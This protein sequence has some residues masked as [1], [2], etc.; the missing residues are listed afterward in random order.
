M[1]F[2]GKKL[3]QLGYDKETIELILDAWRTSTKKVYTTYLKK[4]AVFCVRQGVKILSPKLT[5]AC[6]FLKNISKEGSG[7]GAVN[8]ARSA[9]SAILPQ[10]EGHSFGTHPMVC[11]L[12]KGAYNRNPPKARYTCFWDVRKVFRVFKDWGPSKDLTLKL[13]TLKLTVLLLL[14]TSQRGQTILGLSIDDLEVSNVAVFKLKVLLKHNRLGD[15]LDTIVLK[16]YTESKRLCVVTTLKE[17]LR[18]TK[19]LRK[20]ETQLLISFLKPN[21]AISRDTL[22]RWTIKVLQMADID[23]QKYKGHSTRGASASAAK[24]LGCSLNQ[25]M[26]QAG[27]KSVESF[28]R[29]YDKDLEQETTTVGNTLLQSA[30]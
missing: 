1:P 12:V 29:F 15:R 18:R 26:R 3:R 20:G 14:V 4:W 16:K 2:L 13:L 22:A 25:I 24:R 30:D 10:F 6:T 17:Y 28:S 5:Q 8:T 21:K 19:E 23:T 27:W 9:L 11:W 7:Y